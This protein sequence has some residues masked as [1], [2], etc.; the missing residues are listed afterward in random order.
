M[1]CIIHASSEKTGHRETGRIREKHTD[2][3]YQE[4]A[5]AIIE[6]EKSH[7]LQLLSWRPMKVNGIVP[8]LFQKPETQES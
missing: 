1:L 5:H 3:D 7:V 8:V 2:R 6:A 4:L